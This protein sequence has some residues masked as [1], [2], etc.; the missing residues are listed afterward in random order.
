M[1]GPGDDEPAK[2][3]P[4]DRRRRD[5]VVPGDAARPG[6]ARGREQHQPVARIPARRAPS[7]ARAR[8][9]ANGR[10]RSPARRRR[11]S[12][13]RA[14][15]FGLPFRR[16]RARARPMPVAPAVAGTVDRDDAKARAR[17]DG[18][19]ARR[20]GRRNCRRRHA[21]AAR[22][23][24]RVPSGAVSTQWMR[25]E[26]ISTSWPTGGNRR[27]IRRDIDVR[28]GPQRARS[29]ASD[30]DTKRRHH[31]DCPAT[32]AFTRVDRVLDRLVM[33]RDLLRPLAALSAR[34]RCARP[35]RGSA[36]GRPARR[37]GGDCASASRRRRPPSP[38]I[39]P[40]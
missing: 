35:A 31:S 18:R 37:H 6:M 24:A 2:Q 33:R 4:D 14:D 29:S 32:A 8:R 11:L 9:R 19:R 40:A 30:R 27:S 34:R 23:R 5:G 7:S 13:R 26:P 39:S 28:A 25:P 15:P 10:R 21:P 17:R 22:R 12:Q 16:R 20:E 3:R 36:R 38:P 1:R